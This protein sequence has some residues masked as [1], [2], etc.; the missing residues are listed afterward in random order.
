MEKS[1]GESF[2]DQTVGQSMA[3]RLDR[4]NSFE[5][6]GKSE[7]DR[8]EEIRHAR[9][10]RRGLIH[11]ALVQIS[12]L[13][14]IPSKE[15]D[16]E[17]DKFYTTERRRQNYIDKYEIRDQDEVEEMLSGLDLDN[18]EDFY[19]LMEKLRQVYAD[20]KMRLMIVEMETR[21]LVFKVYGQSTHTKETP[22]ERIARLM[23]NQEQGIDIADVVLA[24]VDSM[25][26]EG[27]DEVSIFRALM[28]KY[29]PDVSNIEKAHEITRL[30]NALW[31]GK[32]KHFVI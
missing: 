8:H 15:L 9:E 3:E 4:E 10:F 13:K 27:K 7:Q 32:T 26:E 2:I 19:L 16:W 1:G 25:R 31:D 14:L 24:E 23:N 6:V 30:I 21:R 29:H 11:D 22:Q 20:L 17:I 12:E 18:S 5:S 28:R